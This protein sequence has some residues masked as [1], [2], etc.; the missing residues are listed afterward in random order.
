MSKENKPTILVIDDTAINL[1]V[2]VT[3]L[4][5]NGY[6]PLS[7]TNGA[8]GVA[9]AQAE[10][11]NLILLDVLM[12]DMNGYEVC[13]TLKTDRTTRNI[14]V[15][16]I[17]A[18]DD[19]LDK[20]RAFSVGGVDYITKPI[21]MAEVLT[22]IKT[23]LTVQRLQQDVAV[24]K[25]DLSAALDRLHEMQRD[26]IHSEKLVVLGQLLA[27]VAH[28]I[29][30]P[31][32]A[33]QAAAGNISKT[34][35]ESIQQL[36]KLLQ[37]LSQE[38]QALFFV[39]I[40][41]AVESIHD[42]V[43]SKEERR[44]RRQTHHFLESHKI[45]NADRHADTFTQMGIY[46][47][48][49][50]FLPLL[51][52]TEAQF[53]MNVAYKLVRQQRNSANISLAV[54]R[55]SKIVFA[56]KTFTHRDNQDSK[57]LADIRETIETVLTIFHNQTRLG[58]E[59]VRHYEDVSSILCYPDQLVQVWSN[60][61]QNALQ[62]MEHKGKL[63]I[64]LRKQKKPPND[65]VE[66]AAEW[67]VVRVIDNGPGIPDAVKPQ[68]FD[69]FFTTKPMGEG[70]GLGL[71]ISRKIVEKHGGFIEFESEPEQTTFKVWLPAIEVE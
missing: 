19:V 24:K 70:N 8:D 48:I 25:A 54:A 36:P 57:T 41:V 7:A 23:H 4:V 34:F 38:N 51:R 1:E 39:L 9:L 45:N 13:E 65:G 10:Q 43:S 53:I 22:R 50:Q 42:P 71:D 46:K 68:I 66:T 29:K 14:P 67:V 55:A 60:L 63:K 47:D 37:Q 20:V 11:P 32:G 17:S 31:L 5:D 61:I 21:Q 52:Q 6:H 69:P 59:V 30:S 27:G 18:L 3:M 40:N 35:T 26:L 44:Y 56:L 49:E 64:D 15:I 28:E 2:L 58:V 16:F 62:A 12:S 33:I